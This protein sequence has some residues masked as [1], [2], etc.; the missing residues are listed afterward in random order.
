MCLARLE[1]FKGWRCATIVDSLTQLQPDSITI[2]SLGKGLCKFR[3]QDGTVFN[4]HSYFGS[5]SIRN[6]RNCIDSW[7]ALYNREAIL[8]AGFLFHNCIRIGNDCYA[9]SYGKRG[10]EMVRVD[11]NV[12]FFPI[13]E[14]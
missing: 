13:T 9:K 14:I 12:R 6:P 7:P 5:N 8:F 2:R 3:L 11:K 10:M 1:A 4:D